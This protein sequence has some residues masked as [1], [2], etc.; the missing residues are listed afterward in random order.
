MLP[1]PAATPRGG[2]GVYGRSE[3]EGRVGRYRLVKRLAAGGMAELHLAEAVG[4]DGAPRMVVVK[5]LREDLDEDELITML[6]EE[7]RIASCLRHPNIVELIEVGQEGKTHFLAMEFVFGRNLRELR[8]RCEELGERIPHRHLVTILADTLDALHH[9]H[10]EATFEGRPLRVI[11]R[12]VSPQNVLVG[13]DGAVKLLDFGMAKASAQ[14]SRTRAGVLKG[15]YAYMSPEQ[16]HFQGVDHRSDLFSV[17]VVLWELLTGRRLFLRHTDYE[18][19]RAVMACQVPFA[20][21]LSPTL[22]WSPSWVAFRAL[23]RDPR[24]RYRDARRMRDAL[25]AGDG[26]SRED[27]RRELAAWMRALFSRPLAQREALLER[28]RDDPARHRMVLESGFELLDEVTDPGVSLR[29]SPG[30]DGETDPAPPPVGLG[31]LGVVSTALGSWRWFALIFTGLV[32]LGGALALYVGAH[33]QRDTAY[34]EIRAD[35]A[36]VAVTVGGR[37]LGATPLDEVAVMPGRHRVVGRAEGGAR[38]VEVTV[39]PG[40][41]KVVNLRFAPAAP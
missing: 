2:S 29:P 5:T 31:L 38:A 21:A 27:A 10:H 20:R 6:L 32:F 19:V 35:R 33:R 40:E 12:D 9:A 37:D 28:L 3:G 34:L 14:Q 18:T 1:A 25:L 41:R 15:K 36:G 30:P 17:G 39:A 24:W 16:V 7:A 4:P 26:R 22:P 13:F 8:E 23:R 11:H